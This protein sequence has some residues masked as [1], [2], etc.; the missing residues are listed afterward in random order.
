[1]KYER[2]EFGAY[3]SRKTFVTYIEEVIINFGKK[4][5]INL[6]KHLYQLYNLPTLLIS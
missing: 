3:K 2:I 5:R 4:Y 6:Y 1:M